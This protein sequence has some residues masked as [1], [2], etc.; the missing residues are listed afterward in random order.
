MSNPTKPTAGNS[1][2]DTQSTAQPFVPLDTSDKLL[3]FVHISDTHIHADPNYK[4]EFVDY[5]A[6]PRVEEMIRQINALEVSIDFVLHTGD[7]MTDPERAEDYAVA[8]E[9]M[10][11]LRYPVYYIPGN[12][13]RTALVQQVMLGRAEDAITP[14]LDY[15]FDHN[16][17][18]FICLDS[19][20]PGNAIG[21][22]A[23][24][25]LKWL[26]ANCKP[27]DPRPLVVAVHHNPLPT[28]APW[29]DIMTLR[30]GAELHDILKPARARIR[31]VFFGHIHEHTVTVR[32]G[33]AYYSS[34]SGWFQTRTW[35]D[36]Q[37][38]ARDPLDIPGFNLVTLTKQDTFVRFYRTPLPPAS[39]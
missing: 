16:G 13:D 20:E 15:T 37:A 6:R 14:Y 23:E 32:D 33:I 31:G 9:V 25:Q 8:R 39:A 28:R 30:Q 29:L 24:P 27:D 19:S 21:K 7:I 34:L 22:L 12:H 3:T 18:Q 38:P 26:A 1:P 36:A 35:F 2:R 10:A 17:V 11:E 5:P 4:S